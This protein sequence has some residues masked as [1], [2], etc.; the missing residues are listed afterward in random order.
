V[1]DPEVYERATATCAR[2]DRG[3][4]WLQVTASLLQEDRPI[5]ARQ[6]QESIDELEHLEETLELRVEQMEDAID[7]PNPRVIAGP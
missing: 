4:M 3:L 6:L 2:M 5:L 1:I 7:E